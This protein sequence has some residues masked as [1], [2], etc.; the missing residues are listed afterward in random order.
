MDSVIE[1]IPEPEKDNEWVDWTAVEFVHNGTAMNLTTCWPTLRAAVL[2]FDYMVPVKEIAR[3]VGCY[4]EYVARLMKK[5][6][7]AKRCLR[8]GRYLISPDGVAP[9]HVMN[10]GLFCDMSGY[11]MDDRDR[12]A[13]LRHQAKVLGRAS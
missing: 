7:N 3:R 2:T 1:T 12:V 4:E 10:T 11:R 13:Q 6:P 8:C 9:R 5:Q